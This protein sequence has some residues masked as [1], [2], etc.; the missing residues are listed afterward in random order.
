MVQQYLSCKGECLHD[1]FVAIIQQWIH[2]I[3]LFVFSFFRFWVCFFLKIHLKDSGTN[4]T[5][6]YMNMIFQ[7]SNLNRTKYF[8][9][10]NLIKDWVWLISISKLHVNDGFRSHQLHLHFEKRKIFYLPLISCKTCNLRIILEK[11][12]DSFCTLIVIAKIMT[13]KKKNDKNVC[14][15]IALTFYDIET[16]LSTEVRKQWKD[17]F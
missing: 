15:Q 5:W 17:E 12:R 2:L 11:T 9:R 14:T 3:P 13:M 10:N 4:C 16:E 7:F 1:S 6:T 8:D